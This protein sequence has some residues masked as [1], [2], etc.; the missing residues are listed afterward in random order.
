VINLTNNTL[1]ISHKGYVFFKVEK[2][3]KKK[4]KKITS[5]KLHRAFGGYTRRTT[6]KGAARRIEHRPKM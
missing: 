6:V 2:R 4:K 3:E 1:L 5:S